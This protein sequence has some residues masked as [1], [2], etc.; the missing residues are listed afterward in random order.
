MTRS[1]VLPFPMRGKSYLAQ[2]VVPYDMTKAE[3]DRLCAFV[4]S[5]AVPESESDV[6]RWR[7]QDTIA[8][9]AA[10]I[11]SEPA[12]EVKEDGIA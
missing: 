5:L 7:R 1:L 4:M 11:P 10:S 2:V 12:T 9:A 6:A 3:A 8:L